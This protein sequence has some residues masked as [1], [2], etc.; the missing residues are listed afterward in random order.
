MH[1]SQLMNMRFLPLQHSFDTQMKH[2]CHAPLH[3]VMIAAAI[4]WEIER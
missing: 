4:S 1:I 2:P 3:R